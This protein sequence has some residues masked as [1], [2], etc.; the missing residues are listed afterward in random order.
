MRVSKW[1]LAFALMPALVASG[2]SGEFTYGSPTAGGGS[3]ACNDTLDN[4]SDGISDYPGDAGCSSP[5]DNDESGD[6]TVVITGA[7]VTMADLAT[8][9][10]GSNA[11][12]CTTTGAAT[13]TTVMVAGAP[14]KAT[15]SNLVTGRDNVAY[16][17]LSITNV[18]NPGFVADNNR[19]VNTYILGN[20]AG[21]IYACAG[22]SG[23]TFHESEIDGNL[24]ATFCSVSQITAV[25]CPW[26]RVTNTYMHD[27]CPTTGGDHSEVWWIGNGSDNVF[28]SGNTYENNGSTAHVF[29]TEGITGVDGDEPQNVCVTG[30]T[31]MPQYSGSFD[32]K[33]RDDSPDTDGILSPTTI[34]FDPSNVATDGAVEYGPACSQYPSCTPYLETQPRTC[35]ECNDG[36]DNDSDGRADYWPDGLGD[37]N[38]FD[39][40]DNTEN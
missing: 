36:I 14:T 15:L 40:A 22:A 11:T 4:D 26:L 23:L 34:Y 9:L 17:D 20:T 25:N 35:I 31:F 29:F 5:F 38:C 3:F 28:F 21:G 19:F 30:E 37:T 2:Q 39:R 7:S 10:A 12:G 32:I 18:P 33:I 13:N 16:N 6:A 1:L 27:V 24:G 8:C